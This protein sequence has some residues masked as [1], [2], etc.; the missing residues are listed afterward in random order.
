MPYSQIDH[1]KIDSRTLPVDALN[2]RRRHVVKMWL[3][4][5]SPK[6]AAAQREMSRTTEIA[7]VRAYEAG[8]SRALEVDHGGRPVG[9]GRTLSREQEPAT[10]I[11]AMQL[12]QQAPAA[13]LL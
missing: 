6:D 5:L 11:A 2:E 9:S 7:A 10:R 8:G 1:G 3:D 12:R 13:S 4:G